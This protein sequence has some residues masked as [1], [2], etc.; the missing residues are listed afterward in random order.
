MTCDA[1]TTWIE[2]GETTYHKCTQSCNGLCSYHRKMKDGLTEPCYSDDKQNKPV[3]V[4]AGGEV[5]WS[6]QA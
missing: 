1:I 4:E 5:L 2:A 3:R 6:G